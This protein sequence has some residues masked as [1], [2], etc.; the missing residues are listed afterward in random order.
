MRWTFGSRRHRNLPPVIQAVIGF[1]IGLLLIIGGIYMMTR[2]GEL[3]RMAASGERIQGQVIDTREESRRVRRNGRTRT[4][5]D[6]YITVQFTHPNGSQVSQEKE[7][8]SS[9][10]SRYSSANVMNPKP[11][12]VVI[13]PEN[14][15]EWMVEEQLA[16]KRQSAGMMAWVLPLIGVLFFGMGGWGVYRKMKG[17]STPPMPQGYPQ[18][19]YPPPPPQ[20]GGPVKYPHP[21]T[22]ENDHVIYDERQQR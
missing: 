20:H 5:R 3:D 13:N 9:V 12:S 16:N 4:E 10:H 2:G 14:P 15:S 11:A 19:S 21:P 17:K 18:Q 7:V 8:A 6:Y 22:N 1:G